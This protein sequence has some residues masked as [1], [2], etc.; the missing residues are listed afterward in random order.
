[1]ESM[2]KWIPKIDNG[3]VPGSAVRVLTYY[4]R[5]PVWEGRPFGK[6]DPIPHDDK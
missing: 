2:R 4:D 5:T 3:P 6:D 1:L